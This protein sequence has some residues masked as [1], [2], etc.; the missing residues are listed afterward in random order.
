MVCP[1]NVIPKNCKNEWRKWWET[2]K[3]TEKIVRRGL[4]D[5]IGKK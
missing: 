2:R 4:I 3:T 1:S 5:E